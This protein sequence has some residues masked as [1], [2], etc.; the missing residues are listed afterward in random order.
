MDWY[1]QKLFLS[2]MSKRQSQETGKYDLVLA[3]VRFTF[4]E[5]T[6]RFCCV[7]SLFKNCRP[8]FLSGSEMVLRSFGHYDIHNC[9]TWPLTHQKQE[10]GL[11]QNPYR[12][13]C[14]AL[15]RTVSTLSNPFLDGR[16][17]PDC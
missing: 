9:D 17:A 6:F 11:G 3:L 4:Y 16:G 14:Q 1:P 10:H 2:R 7:L 5:F 15:I 8:P 12:K 13:T